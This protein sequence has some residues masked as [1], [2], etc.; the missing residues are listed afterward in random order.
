[1]DSSS[2]GHTVKAITD[3]MRRIYCT[4][5]THKFTSDTM[6]VSMENRPR[7]RS[8]IKLLPL[9][10]RMTSQLSVLIFKM[11]HVQ[12]VLLDIIQSLLIFM[13]TALLKDITLAFSFDYTRNAYLKTFLFLL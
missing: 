3:I 10:S 8:V 1:M 13:F 4:V 11:H 7:R 2:V 5:H 12:S 9:I 6:V